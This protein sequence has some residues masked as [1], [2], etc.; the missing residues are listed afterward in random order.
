[1]ESELDAEAFSKRFSLTPSAMRRISSGADARALQDEVVVVARVRK[2]DQSGWGVGY[3]AQGDLPAAEVSIVNG[4]RIFV[5]S[6]WRVDLADH[7]LDF[8]DSGFVIHPSNHEQ[9]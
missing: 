9:S 4:V 5:D 7:T 8:R 1:M 2:D 6:Q 3:M